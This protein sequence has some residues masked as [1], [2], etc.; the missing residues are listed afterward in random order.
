M[1]VQIPPHMANEIH[2]FA[3]LERIPITTFVLRGIQR[4]LD[5]AAKRYSEGEYQQREVVRPDEDD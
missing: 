3:E 4:E 5:L 1:T 2:S